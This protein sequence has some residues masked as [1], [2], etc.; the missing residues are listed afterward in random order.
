MT[1]LQ[2]LETG[3]VLKLLIPTPNSTNKC[4]FNTDRYV[5]D[6]RATVARDYKYLKFL[7]ILFGV[8]MRTK[9]PLDL[10][11]ARP[12]WKLLAGMNMTHD[13]LEEVQFMGMGY[14]VT[15][16]IYV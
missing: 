13:D 4:G 3:V 14:S 12:M 1:E 10:H 9:K 6:P 11:L 5:L 8:A 15:N 16:Q 7:G 2:E